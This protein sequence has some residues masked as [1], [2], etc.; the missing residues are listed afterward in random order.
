MKKI[1]FDKQ[2]STE[3]INGLV[4]NTVD[5]SKKTASKA[6]SNVASIVEKTKND[7]IARKLKKLNPL[8]PEQYQSETFNIP[9]VIVIKDDAERRNEKLCKGAIGWLGTAKNGVEIL[10]LYDEAVEFSGIKFVPYATCDAIYC[11]DPFDRNRFI[12]ADNIFSKAQEE[13]LAEL[14]HIANSL[15]AKRCSI[16]IIEATL[17]KKSSSNLVSSGENFKGVNVSES[18]EQSFSSS[19]SDSIS[20]RVESEFE[21]NDE[22]KEPTLKWFAHDDIIKG[23]I[24][25]RSSGNN[26]VKKE[27]FVLSVASSAAMTQKTAYAIDGEIGKLGGASAQMSMNSQAAKEHNSKLVYYIEF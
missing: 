12:K 11:V 14:K 26:S 2:K 8:F 6:K 27:T 3:A 13:R 7:S 4:Q 18:A 23:L 10:Y 1:N 5:L 22:P 19:A 17:D 25:T 20:G 9:N 15:G 16:E 24:E 21:G